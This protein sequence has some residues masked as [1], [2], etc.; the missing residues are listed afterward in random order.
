MK[1]T[2]IDTDESEEHTVGKDQVT[3]ENRQ[4]WFYF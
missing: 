1:V 3:E 4:L 2:N